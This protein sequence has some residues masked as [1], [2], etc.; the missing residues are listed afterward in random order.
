MT[1]EDLS[2]EGMGGATVGEGI[3]SGFGGGVFG[4]TESGAVVR[5]L[6]D[7]AVKFDGGLEPWRVIGTF[8]N[9]HV[10]RQI[11]AAPLGQLLKLVLV[12]F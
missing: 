2:G 10:G 7:L 3:E 5:G 4:L 8:P 9:R 1:H 11:K 12:H 6:E